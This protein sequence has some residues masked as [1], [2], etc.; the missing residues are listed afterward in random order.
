RVKLTNRLKQSLATGDRFTQARDLAA[1][2]GV[3]P[4]SRIGL[5]QQAER[6]SRI[7]R[8]GLKRLAGLVLHLI[9]DSLLAILDPFLNPTQPWLVLERLAITCASATPIA[10]I[11]LCFGMQQQL[12]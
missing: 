2:G 4:A 3:Q 11:G 7:G 5:V 9:G 12:G 1:C 10:L 6:T 8:Q